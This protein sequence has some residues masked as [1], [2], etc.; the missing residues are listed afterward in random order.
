MKIILSIPLFPF[1]WKWSFHRKLQLQ[2]LACFPLISFPFNLAPRNDNLGRDRESHFRFNNPLNEPKN[3]FETLKLMI[4]FSLG[5]RCRNEPQS[6][7]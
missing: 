6:S 4:W 7:T 2:L 3:S 1:V 5:M